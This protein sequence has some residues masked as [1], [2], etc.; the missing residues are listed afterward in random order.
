MVTTMSIFITN[1]FPTGTG[2]TERVGNRC[3][4]FG[5]S[6]LLHW[7]DLSLEIGF[8]LFDSFVVVNSF[9]AW[10]NHILKG[11]PEKQR[12]WKKCGIRAARLQLIAR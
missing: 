9:I 8:S 12:T 1:L 5:S 6:C 7:V 11:K 10:R 2:I 4:Y 3:G